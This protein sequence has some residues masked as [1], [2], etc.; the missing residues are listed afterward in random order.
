MARKYAVPAPQRILQAAEEL[1]ADRGYAATGVQDIADRAHINKRMIFYYF[2][3][4][5]GLYAAMAAASYEQVLR[6]VVAAGRAKLDVGKPL[7]ALVALTG[8]Y[9]DTLSD[10]PR[11]VRF[12][13]W[14]AAAEWA[15]LNRTDLH[16]LTDGV[17]TLLED[18]LRAG[19][20]TGVFDPSLDIAA[21]WQQITGAVVYHFIFRPRARVL[22]DQDFGDPGVRDLH[23]RE[24]IRFILR[25]VLNHSDAQSVAAAALDGDAALLEAVAGGA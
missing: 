12:I 17:R 24:T 5:E 22:G 23:R 21:T 3:S 16:E 19:V 7:A 10:H 6:P 14:E 8:A 13:T 9:Y 2:V 25:A 18:I 1:F 4:K 15:M 20:A 11:F